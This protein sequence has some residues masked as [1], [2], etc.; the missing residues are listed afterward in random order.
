MLDR[1]L[2]LKGKLGSR[3]DL[4]LRR[5]RSAYGRVDEEDQLLDLSIAFE[6]LLGDD[7]PP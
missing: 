3:L 5:L 7:L 1:Y 6:A 4:A 2:A